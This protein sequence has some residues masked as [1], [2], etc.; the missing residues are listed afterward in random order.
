MN[1]ARSRRRLPLTIVIVGLAVFFG[2]AV[3]ARTLFNQQE[4]R[5]LQQRVNEAGAALQISVGNIKTPLD[6]AVAVAASSDGDPVA[7]MKIISPYVGTD[8]T[9]QSAALFKIGTPTPTVQTGTPLSLSADGQNAVAGMLD[10]ATSNPFIVVGLLGADQRRL[11]YAVADAPTGA[12]YVAYAERALSP[13]PYVR[14]RNDEPFAQLNYA[15]YIGDSPVT[16][17]LLQASVRDLPIPGRTADQTVPFGNSRLLLVMTPIGHLS[18]DLFANL[19]WI[20]AVGGVLIAGALAILTRRLLDGRD[21]A[22]GLA[23]DNE[24]LYDEQRHIAETLQLGLLP[25]HLAAPEGVSVAAR[26]W[27]AG[28]ANLI[29]GDFYDL[30]AIDEERWGLAIGDVC[31]KGIEAAALTGLARHTLRAAARY[32]SSPVEVLQAVHQAL[33]DHEPPTFCTACFAYIRRSGD[34]SYRVDLSLGG[35]PQPLLQHSDG[36]VETVGT[37]GMLLGMIEPTLSTSVVELDPGDTLVFFTDGLTDAPA[38]EAVSVDELAALMSDKRDQT[39][40]QMADS[41][42]ALKRSRRP[43]GSGDDTALLILRIDGA[44]TFS[45]HREPLSSDE[46][47]TSGGSR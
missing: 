23:A 14:R 39:I 47:A 35:H 20:V 30:F 46:P 4:D 33:R 2:L 32:S 25:Q 17:H 43:G 12:K 10:S 24:R 7:F 34:D 28:S 1:A 29:G 31:G 18:G 16:D 19:W 44:A 38:D 11:G 8:K 40:E 21:T 41:I 36:T 37:L 26:Y 5:L 42:R 3:G 9:Y 22:L 13:D 15:I 6:A 27:P 45:E